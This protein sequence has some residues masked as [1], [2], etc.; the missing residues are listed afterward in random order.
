[1]LRLEE[2]LIFFELARDPC[3]HV[4]NAL[5]ISLPV[6]TGQVRHV[7]AFRLGFDEPKQISHGGG[8]SHSEGGGECGP[9]Y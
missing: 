4:G 6:L 5:F 8:A 1:M 2:R 3:N 7:A 9:P